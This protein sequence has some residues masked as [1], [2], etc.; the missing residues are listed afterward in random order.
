[1]K[2]IKIHFFFWF[3][4]IGFLLLSWYWHNTDSYI[5]V[6]V[7]DTYYVIRQ[8]HLSILFAVIY[9]FLG[10]VY[11][12]FS[13]SKVTLNRILFKIHSAITLGIVP[14]FF[15]GEYILEAKKKSDFPLF[16]DNSNFEYFVFILGL[17][18]VIAQLL[19]ILNVIFS[20]LKSL[21]INK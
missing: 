20:L 6:N 13:L 12:I 15:I 11:F 5:D 7:H 10:F 9:A 1:M 18:F 4:T 8:S 2:K 17:L 14:L 19:F 16:D 3:V 21:F